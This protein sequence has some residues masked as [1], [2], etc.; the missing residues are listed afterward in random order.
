MLLLMCATIAGASI[1]SAQE[2]MA[3]PPPPPFKFVPQKLT[4]STRVQAAKLY[5]RDCASCH[6]K[7]GEGNNNGLSLY[8]SK[9]PQHSAAAMH[10]GKAQ[11]PP[12]T[13]VMPAYGTEKFLTQKE[14]A[15]IAAYIA[16]FRPPYP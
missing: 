13:M 14:I 1:A 15:Q 10:F 6:G 9:D 8:G 2:A 7:D 11:P 4:P 3:L 16:E 12:L 5:A